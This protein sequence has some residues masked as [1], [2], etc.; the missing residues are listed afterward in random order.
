MPFRVELGHT[1]PRCTLDNAY[2]TLEPAHLCCFTNP[3]HRTPTTGQLSLALCAG[4]MVGLFHLLR[5]FASGVRVRA[6]ATSQ[7]LQ[8]FAVGV[9]AQE[10][11]Q[12]AGGVLASQL[13]A[14]IGF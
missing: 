14:P 3:A 8:V 9:Q 13:A 2:S 10:Q 1:R 7:S 12:G 5:Q 4:R 6:L 11:G